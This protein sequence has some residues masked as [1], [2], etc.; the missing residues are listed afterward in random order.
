M[1]STQEVI[2]RL[3]VAAILGSVIGLERERLEKAAGLRTHALV[4]LGSALIII[5]SAFGFSDILGQPN[6]RLDPSRIAAQVV[7]GIGFLGAGTIIFRREVVRGLTTAASIWVAAGI[8]LAAGAGLYL[9]AVSG[10][11]LTLIVLAGIRSVERYF[12]VQH[13]SR[14]I[15][16][17]VS[18]EQPSI[19]DLEALV[20]EMGL[21]LENITVRPTSGND[22]RRVTLA[23]YQV[24]MDELQTLISRLGEMPGVRRVEMMSGR[25]RRLR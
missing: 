12:F 1:I 23:L 2:I 19:R 5:V 10:T 15:G 17:T 3:V 22:D 14:R 25:I 20:D 24:H 6:V 7:S 4:C 11:I 13:G 16:L 21:N 8:G 18:P 9:A